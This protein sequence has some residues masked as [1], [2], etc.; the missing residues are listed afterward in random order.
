M[1]LKISVQHNTLRCDNGPE[2]V[3][4]T[5]KKWA[6]QE[7][8]EIAYIQPGNPQQNA[9][10]KRF[11]RTVRYDWLNQDVFAD[12]EAV[13]EKAT[14]WLWHYNHER[15][16]MGLGGVTPKQKLLQAAYSILLFHYS[17][18]LD[19]GGLPSRYVQAVAALW[20]R[21]CL[22]AQLKTLAP[23]VQRFALTSLSPLYAKSQ[24][25]YH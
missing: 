24:L 13:T 18:S 9:T 21:I 25:A 11:N 7:G 22:G 8:I 12:I 23:Q 16:N 14:R 19:L 17:M 3:S 2:Y 15:P 4:G 5:L 10:I 6:T 1:F 20:H